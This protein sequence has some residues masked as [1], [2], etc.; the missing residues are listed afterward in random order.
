[1]QYSFNWN[2]VS[3][4]FTI[5]HEGGLY[6]TF[7]LLITLIELLST[8]FYMYLA[9][10]R[11]DMNPWIEQDADEI[12]GNRGKFIW[13]FYLMICIEGVILFNTILKFF[14]TYMDD[15]TQRKV[16]DPKKIRNHY[17]RNGFLMDVIP[18]LPFQLINLSKG[19]NTLFYLI[20]LIRLWNCFKLFDVAELMIV[21]RKI[22]KK[23][24]M[25]KNCD[26]QMEDHN[27]IEDI[28][29]IGYFL[30]I[31]RL[32]LVILNLAFIIAMI[33]MIYCTCV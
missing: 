21:V 15:A 22:F 33:W 7:H 26:C 13:M 2:K 11:I 31:S 3:K 32:I 30:K 5:D 6:F 12:K 23:R 25:M 14:L 29:I 17:L 24:E 10:F 4:F 18:L 27:R 8:Q 19:R 16:T 28:L 1:M 9:A 20:K